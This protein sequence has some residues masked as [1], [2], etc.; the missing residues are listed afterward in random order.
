[1]LNCWTLRKPFNPRR[2]VYSTLWGMWFTLF[3]STSAKSSWV[4][5]DLSPLAPMRWKKKKKSH[6]ETFLQIRLWIKKQWKL[7][8][9]NDR[10][11]AGAHEFV[12]VGVGF[13]LL[14]GSISIFWESIS[15]FISSHYCEIP[16]HSSTKASWYWDIKTLFCTLFHYFKILGHHFDLL[17]HFLRTFHV[18]NE[19]NILFSH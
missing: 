15:L 8:Q 5:Y 10:E 14:W 19:N 3:H 11:L 2:P 6:K 13:S 9:Y 4:E 12:T 1:M 17:S 16:S 18:I 7:S